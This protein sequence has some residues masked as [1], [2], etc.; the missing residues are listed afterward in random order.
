MQFDKQMIRSKDIEGRLSCCQWLFECNH[1]VGGSCLA[2][3]VMKPV[4]E[5]VIQSMCCSMK[6]SSHE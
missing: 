6:I 4:S 3:I 1:T 5:D 2:T